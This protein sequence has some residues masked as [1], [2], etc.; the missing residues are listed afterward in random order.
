MLPLKIHPRAVKV[1][2]IRTFIS[3]FENLPSL[4]ICLRISS[5][6]AENSS[7]LN[8]KAIFVKYNQHIISRN[9]D[10][11]TPNFIQSNIFNFIP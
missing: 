3:S 5:L 4:F 1:N 2:T 6:P 9:D 8:L 10:N 11:G 7:F